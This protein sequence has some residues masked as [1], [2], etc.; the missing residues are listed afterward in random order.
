MTTS[1]N[2]TDASTNEAA[3]GLPFLRTWPAVYWFVL[4]T[5]VVWIALLAGLTAVFA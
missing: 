1:P 2:T 3:T 5:L 4:V